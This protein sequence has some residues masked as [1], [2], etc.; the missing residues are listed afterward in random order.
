[1]KKQT[2]RI[3][4]MLSLFTM[5]AVASAHAQA[6]G[7]IRV[8]I[9]FDFIVKDTTLPAGEYTVESTSIEPHDKL[10]PLLVIRSADGRGHATMVFANPVE[11]STGQAEA[12]LVF[13]RYGN[14]YFLSQIWTPANNVGCEL[15]KSSLEREL[16]KSAAKPQTAVIA[17]RKS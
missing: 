12:K 5:L 16:A 14:R 4:T 2:F 7:V 1:M 15:I 8:N 9:P 13:N 3:F 6:A 10:G 11:A 17:V